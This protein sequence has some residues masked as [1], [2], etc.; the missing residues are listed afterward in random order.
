[1]KIEVKGETLFVGWNHKRE[2]DEKGTSCIITKVEGEPI[3]V[4][5]S[6]LAMGDT[7]DKKIGRKLS[8]TRAMKAAEFSREDRKNIWTAYL[9]TQGTIQ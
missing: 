6:L 1:M 3:A 5:K 2:G 9:T 8:L 4:G 7:F